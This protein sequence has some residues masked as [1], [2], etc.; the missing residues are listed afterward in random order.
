MHRQYKNTL[1]WILILFMIHVTYGQIGR[2]TA[3][4][5]RSGKHDGNRVFC[6]F[7]NGGYTT[8]NAWK[9][10]ENGYVIDIQPLV[11][12]QLPV[13]DYRVNGV[14][15]G[16]P[17]TITS[18]ITCATH[19]D[20]DM[21]PSGTK[22]WGFEPIPG[23]CNDE[24]QGRDIGVAMSHQP[25]TWPPY[26]PDHPDW[27]DD[28]GDAEW[29]GYFGRGVMSADQESYFM[30]DDN[31]DEK[32]YSFHAFL[33]DSNDANRKGQG[34]RVSVRGLQWQNPLAQDI[35]FWIYKVTNVGTTDYDRVSFGALV[36]TYVGGAGTEWN[37]DASFFNIRESIVYSWDYDHYIS[38]TANPNWVGDP[39]EVGYIGY[40]FL[41][42]PGRYWDGIDN[43]GDNKN[44]PNSSAPYFDESCFKPRT[45][46][47]GDKV[48]LIDRKSHVR[49][50]FTVPDTTV[51]VISMDRTFMLVPGETV[52]EEGNMIMGKTGPELNP[53]A[54]DGIDNDLDG[55][56]DENYQL[57]FHQYKESVDGVVL[58][59]TE[60][61]VQY[62]DYFTG[63][64][65]DDLMLDESR[66]D[67][68]D[69]DGDWDPKQDDVGA[70]GKADTG[71]P[72]E[73]DGVPT[74]GEPH[75]D[76]KDVD[77]SDQIGL[78]SFDYFVPSTDVHPNDEADMWERLKPGRFDV[79]E[80]VVDN[81]PIR[82][83]DGDF[84]F[85]SGYF[86]LYAGETQS[87]SIALVYGDNYQSVVRTKDIA[88]LIYNSN[89]NFPRAPERP[90]VHAVGMNGK[91]LLYWDRVAESSYD[92]SLQEYDF[93]GYKIYKST[94]PNFSDCKVLTNGYGEG[95]AEYPYYQ[96][97]LD[98]DVKGFFYPDEL[99][100]NLVNGQPYYLGD[101]TG[102]QNTFVD[103]DVENGR[104]YYY[105]VCAYDH[106]SVE[107]SIYP[108]EN[109]K[110]ITQDITGAMTFERNT[111]MV[112]PN[113]PVSD[114][115][116]PKVSQAMNRISGI[117]T[118]TPYV[119]IVDEKNVKD[120]S[121]I[122]TF[123]NKLYRNEVLIADAYTVT[124]S[125]TGDTIM[126]T[127]DY[128]GPTN[129]DVFDGIRLSFNTQYQNLNNVFMD[130]NTTA[131][132]DTS[133]HDIE[134]LATDFEFKN[135]K[136]IRCP[137]DYMLVFHNN[138][139]YPSSKL[140]DIFG[141]S[142][143]LRVIQTNLEIFDVTDPD[144]PKPIEFGLL[145][146]PAYPGTISHFA[147]IFL[148][149]PDSTQL[150]WR[151]VFKDSNLTNT[152]TP[153]GDG[154]TLC[155]VF[156]KPFTAS[157]RFSFSMKP[158]ILNNTDMKTKLNMVKV[159]PNPYI[160]SSEFEKPL[161]YGLR[162]RG[163]RIMYFTHV[164]SGADIRIYSPDGT[165]VRHLKHENIA[166][167][168]SVIWDLKSAEGLD[169]SYG[170]YFY[171][172]EAG[173]DSKS[174]KLAIIK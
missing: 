166:Q 38:P 173:S 71:D 30:M 156:Q 157:D 111:V 142:A 11:G 152:F 57:H 117:S 161:V 168:G 55:L 35:I 97:D 149:T 125:L 78:T 93:E 80:S 1:I 96:M 7:T 172:V 167:D 147:T 81:R 28:D 89:Y 8:W 113:A 131:W 9:Y 151:L 107:K 52:L 41:E 13:A 16:I 114:Y 100:Y 174:G 122:V 90:T 116:P 145:D 51:S 169:V 146:T 102:I 83:E 121:Y 120:A 137:Y 135:V 130:T 54:Y 92:K 171:I 40:S 37:D 165:L 32:M 85:G 119:E 162:G 21:N 31:A 73:N 140:T 138:Y 68:I 153:P 98:N 129:G 159:V 63:Q 46:E 108:S 158:S 18:T 66:N 127:N 144:T 48:I 59:D 15:D 110:S 19:S 61:P 82:G 43:D 10:Y 69:N 44:A 99:L 65:K 3:S 141:S 170:V 53:N 160:V 29:N 50:I 47:S 77:E 133:L 4:A 27:I 14:Y 42:S 112:T 33:P 36:G 70:D 5:R 123:R 109:S 23:F 24:V 49:S 134:V 128:W 126:A 103:E 115:V 143:P 154:D 72:G 58:L 139:T 76:S 22:F 106:G 17:D 132:N 87:F 88:Q 94:D 2:G 26:W 164:P 105:A 136:S 60:N 67:G 79:P 124:D 101:D 75:F 12:M 74:D 6:N 148:T 86:P 155:V 34:I 64:G 45:I 39:D 84:I 104:T 20:M 95:V 150:S 62:I 163:E 56:V 25:Q 118:A 91:V